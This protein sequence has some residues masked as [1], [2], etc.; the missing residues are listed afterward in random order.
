[1]KDNWGRYK[2]WGLCLHSGFNLPDSDAWIGY[3][4]RRQTFN[5]ITWK[6]T[7]F[8]LL[9][10]PYQTNCK[11][12]RV[13][14][15]YLSRT[16]CIRKCKIQVSVD[17]CGVIYKGIDLMRS[18]SNVRFG[19]NRSFTQKECFYDLNFTDICVKRCSHF[20][21]SIDHYK[22]VEL[23]RTTDKHKKLNKQTQDTI[24]KI[25]IPTEPE[26]S[27][28]HQPRIDLVEFIC[29]LASTFNFWFGFS[30]ISFYYF[31]NVTRN[32][33][34]N[35]IT[36]KCEKNQDILLDKKIITQKLGKKGSKNQVTIQ[37]SLEFST[38]Y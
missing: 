16:D 18:D 31:F 13:N 29:Y 14:G 7:S 6:L 21:C 17:K 38:W 28:S 9:E 19:N 15:Q 5:M 2:N 36:K 30:V 34:K 35:K 1:M 22:T 26:T 25:Q 8:R 27:Y 37:R 10:S 11:D 32:R 33:V 20:D 23:L 4:W 3:E 24:I 12:Y